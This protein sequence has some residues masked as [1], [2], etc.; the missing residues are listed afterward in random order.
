MVDGNN[1]V[2]VARKGGVKV[3]DA[4]ITTDGNSLL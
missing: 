4:A 2:K 1:H 3:L